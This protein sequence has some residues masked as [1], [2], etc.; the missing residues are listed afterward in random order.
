[1]VPGVSQGGEASPRGSLLDGKVG[2]ALRQ[3][4]LWTWDIIRHVPSNW[5]T[6]RLF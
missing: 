3:L 6:C 1:V 2:A 5:L 4:L